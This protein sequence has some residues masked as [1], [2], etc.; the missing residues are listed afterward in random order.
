MYPH[1]G[2]FVMYVPDVEEVE[3]SS[4]PKLLDLELGDTLITLEDSSDRSSNIRLEACEGPVSRASD[5]SPG[6]TSPASAQQA[7]FVSSR[8]A[9]CSPALEATPLMV[10][11]V[12]TFEGR[13]AALCRAL[14]PEYA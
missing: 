12:L 1:L 2:A 6:S 14:A 11:I 13:L 9:A 3:T 7:P 4:T 8:S 10:P 5:P